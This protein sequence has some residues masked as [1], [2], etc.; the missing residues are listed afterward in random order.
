MCKLLGG[1]MDNAPLQMPDV[2]N[3]S[4]VDTWEPGG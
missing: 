1:L 4:T 2:N 3:F